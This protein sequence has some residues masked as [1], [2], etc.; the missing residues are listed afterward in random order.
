ML[1]VFACVVWNSKCKRYVVVVDVFL[2]VKDV[3]WRVL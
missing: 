2:L 1:V 3:M